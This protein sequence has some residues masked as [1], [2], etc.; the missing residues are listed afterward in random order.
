M[1][2]IEVPVQ[3]SLDAIAS[4]IDPS[5]LPD[6]GVRRQFHREG[7]S[8]YYVVTATPRTVE[9][10]TTN[11]LIEFVASGGERF[12]ATAPMLPDNLRGRSCLG[13][14]ATHPPLPRQTRPHCHLLSLL[15]IEFD[16]IDAHEGQ[17]Q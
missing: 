13:V 17:A 16:G 5:R 4:R 1:V 7:Q 10:R 11:L 8:R 15:P 6:Y 14:F 3:N 9:A 2:R 12:F